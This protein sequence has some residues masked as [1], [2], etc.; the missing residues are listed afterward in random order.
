MSH[1]LTINHKQ[2]RIRP[3]NK[4]AATIF[5]TNRDTIHIEYVQQNWTSNDKYYNNLLDRFIN[6]LKKN[7]LNLAKKKV[8][9]EDVNARM[10]YLDLEYG[11]LPHSLYSPDLVPSE[12]FQTLTNGDLKGLRIGKTLDRLYGAQREIR[13][14]YSKKLS[15]IQKMLLRLEWHVLELSWTWLR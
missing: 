8:I 10:R 9:V 1:L 13:R 11:L 14:F 4:V 7:R 3:F 12:C 6:D 5:G 2:D 15:F